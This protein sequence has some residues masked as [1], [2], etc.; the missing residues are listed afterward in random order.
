MPPRRSATWM[1]QLDDRILEHLEEEPWSSPSV[2]DSMPEFDASEG[3]VRE[4]CRV[5]ADAELVAFVVGDM[6]EITRWGLLYLDGGIDAEHRP[7][8]TKRALRG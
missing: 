8:P 3:R 7:L 5:L 6:V 1:Q 4:R 2:M